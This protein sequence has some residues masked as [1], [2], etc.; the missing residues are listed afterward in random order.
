MSHVEYN[1]AIPKDFIFSHNFLPSTGNYQYSLYNMRTNEGFTFQVNER[2][3]MLIPSKL[4]NR[5]R[6]IVYFLSK[7]FEECKAGFE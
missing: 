2:E 3:Y 4:I 5:V 7:Q 6:D 1:E